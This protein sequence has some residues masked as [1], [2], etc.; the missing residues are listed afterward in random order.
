M[1]ISIVLQAK[2]TKRNS[3][4]NDVVIYLFYFIFLSHYRLHVFQCFVCFNFISIH[5]HTQKQEKKQ[6]YTGDKKIST[7]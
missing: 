4:V 2:L 6:K 5:Y 1:L 7:T 3:V